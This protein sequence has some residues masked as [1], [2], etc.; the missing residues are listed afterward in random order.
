[1]NENRVLIKCHYMHSPLQAF[2]FSFHFYV[3]LKIGA[4]NYDY[5]QPKARMV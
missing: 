3:L 2:D 4:L 5:D 1:M